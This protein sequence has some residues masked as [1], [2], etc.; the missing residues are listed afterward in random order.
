[1]ASPA[2]VTRASAESMTATTAGDIGTIRTTNN[3]LQT[4]IQAATIDMNDK[5]LQNIQKVHDVIESEA[6]I[7]EAQTTV[8]IEAPD[9]D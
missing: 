6:I 2:L 3:D 7:A 9:R 1:M 5:T 8:D 4:S